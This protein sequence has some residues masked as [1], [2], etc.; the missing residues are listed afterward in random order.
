MSTIDGPIYF[1]HNATTPLDPRVRDA[2]LPWLGGLHGNPSSAHGF[3]RR[4]HRAVED[5]R[6][7][8][9]ALL[10]TPGQWFRRGGYSRPVAPFLYISVAYSRWFNKPAD[11]RDDIPIEPADSGARSLLGMM[12]LVLAG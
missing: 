5:A 12:S 8:V 10:S 4:A 1:D 9:A 11:G 3:G 7:K 2:M 6:R